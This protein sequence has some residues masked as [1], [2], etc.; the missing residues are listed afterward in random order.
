MRTTNIFTIISTLVL[1]VFSVGA[2]DFKGLVPL[3]STCDDVKRILGVDECKMPQSNYILKEFSIT[4]NFVSIESSERT[5]FCY[6]VPTGRITSMVVSYYK[7]I[8]IK[9]FGYELK[10]K[11][12]PFGDIG[13][14]A[15]SN[16]EKGISVF[17]D[18]G[19]ITTAIFMPTLT[20]RK[21]LTYDCDDKTVKC[22]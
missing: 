3:E 7:P 10:Y 20:Q 18:N 15:Y 16:E 6:R 19:L 2:Q 8:P 9:E 11:E 22:F 14:I 12:G 5:G 21:K 4:I 13:T 17:T 1:F